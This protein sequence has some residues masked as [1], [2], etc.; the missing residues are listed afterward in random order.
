MNILF[1][2]EEINLVSEWAFNTHNELCCICR[3]SIMDISVNASVNDPDN[4]NYNT[5]KPIVGECNHAF[6]SDCINMWR[7]HSNKCPLCQSNW[8]LK[9]TYNEN[10]VNNL[11]N[12]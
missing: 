6:H 11:N 5:C 1:E 7:R 2:I 9:K 12:S 4:I 10:Y 3:N 8:K